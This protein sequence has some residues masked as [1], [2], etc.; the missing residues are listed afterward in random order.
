MSSVPSILSES[1]EQVDPEIAQVLDDEL[2]RQRDTLEMIASENFV[3]KAV[4]QAQG[5]SSQTS[6]RKGTRGD[7]TTEGANT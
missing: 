3:P 1:L 5:R 6:T 2:Q 7:A 4:L